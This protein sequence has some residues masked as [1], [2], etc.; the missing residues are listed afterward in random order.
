LPLR[1]AYRLIFLRLFSR[2]FGDRDAASRIAAALL[3]REMHSLDRG[4]EEFL[5]KA[6]NMVRELQAS[7]PDLVQE[8]AEAMN[9]AILAMMLRWPETEITQLRYA[10]IT[11]PFEF[12]RTQSCTVAHAAPREIELLESELRGEEHLTDAQA[13]SSIRRPGMLPLLA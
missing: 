5:S 12:V 10:R 3:K 9:C 1:S 13:A 2:I 7:R 11:E 6:I 8:L 4:S